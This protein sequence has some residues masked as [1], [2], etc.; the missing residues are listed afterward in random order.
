LTRDEANVAFGKGICPT[1]AVRPTLGTLPLEPTS[2]M[3][4]AC[5]PLDPAI[6]FAIRYFTLT[7]DTHSHV[8]PTIQKRAAEK[9]DRIFGKMTPLKAAE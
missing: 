2:Q 5:S 8:L 9:M 3:S 6:F 1:N 7:L 4:P